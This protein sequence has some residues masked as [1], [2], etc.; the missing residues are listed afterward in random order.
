MSIWSRIANV[1][2]GDRLRRE[3]DE[4]I[5]SHIDEAV[6]HGRDPVEVR[7][8]FGSALH[9][10][11]RSGDIKLV[12]WLDSV[13]A[14]LVFGWRQ[15]LKH[16]T[17]SVAAILSLALA[18]GACTAAFRLIDALLLRPLPI[19]DPGRLYFLT[20]Q[21]RGNDGKVDTG[22]SFDYPGFRRLRESVKGSAELMAISYNFRGDITY[23]SDQEMEKIYRQFISGW[24]LS[25]FGLKPAAGRLL[26]ADD[27]RKPGAHPYAVLSY[28]YWSRRFGR[29]PRTIGRTF[30]FGNDIYEVVGVVEKGFTGTEPGTLTD[31]FIPT[32][33]EAGAINEP[34]NSWFRTWVR[35]RPDASADRV[36]EKLRATLLAS[37]REQ[38]KSWNP[39]T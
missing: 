24:T 36:R 10:R 5:Q 11:E 15:I 35:L 25:S 8:A 20:Y 38:V 39:G 29:D 17:A 14:D 3:I 26:S 32:M 4:E 28:D 22:D 34:N 18:I 13:R 9:T 7:R 27:D 1:F 33:M 37:R 6:E 23:G 2:R 12:A 21:Y 19:A 30:R 31:L 16:R